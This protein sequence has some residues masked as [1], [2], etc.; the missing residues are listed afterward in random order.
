M[1]PNLQPPF[2]P[3]NPTFLTLPPPFL[4][5]ELK[6]EF[7]E[8]PRQDQSQFQVGEIPAQAVA[9]TEGKGVKG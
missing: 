2:L 6:I 3:Q 5:H 8:Q 7:P 4:I 1:N 9:G